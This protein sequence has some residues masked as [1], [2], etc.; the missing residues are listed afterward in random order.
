MQSYGTG[1]AAPTVFINKIV[2]TCFFTLVWLIPVIT[3]T[4]NTT[5][6]HWPAQVQ[7]PVPRY[8]YR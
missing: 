4:D 1:S 8:R 2:M 3:G 6:E 5:S 7:V